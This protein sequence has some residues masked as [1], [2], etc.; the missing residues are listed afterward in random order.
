[1]G[2]YPTFMGKMTPFLGLFAGSQ[3]SLGSYESVDGGL[4]WTKTSDNYVPLERQ[5]W[6]ELEVKDPS[7]SVFIVD[8]TDIIREWSELDVSE[9]SGVG[10]TP[11]GRITAYG[12]SGSREV[13]YSYEYLR[14]GGNRWMQALDKRDVQDRA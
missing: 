3:A 2:C 9:P 12:T 10:F 14:R 13:V 5:E 8:G 7:G 4:T 1:M 6:S 11:D